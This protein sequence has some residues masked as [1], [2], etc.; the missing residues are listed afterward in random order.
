MTKDQLI[1]RQKEKLN[2]AAPIANRYEEFSLLNRAKEAL[3][4]PK[5]AP[6]DLKVTIAFP[7]KEPVTLIPWDDQLM[8]RPDFR[9]LWDTAKKVLAEHE[10]ANF[11]NYNPEHENEKLEII[12]NSI[13]VIADKLG[14]NTHQEGE[15]DYD[16][17]WEKHWKDVRH[18]PVRLEAF[19]GLNR[20]NSP[21]VITEVRPGSAQ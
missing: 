15:N 17:D 7:G 12:K 9:E 11:A 8:D 1:A 4:N 2:E 20:S 18:K 14:D 16:N 19:E 3:D 6:K 21:V 5:N 10:T 13:K